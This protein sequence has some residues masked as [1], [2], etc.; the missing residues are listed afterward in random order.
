[1][2]KYLL[3][4][5]ICLAALFSSGCE[6]K[7]GILRDSSAYVSPNIQELVVE[8]DNL[9]KEV[10]GILRISCEWT[11]PAPVS[12]A[13]AYLA[14][15]QSIK[16]P[17]T[18]P[19]GILPDTEDE[20]ENGFFSIRNGKSLRAQ[21]AEAAPRPFEDSAKFYELFGT[22]MR[23]ESKIGT[24]KLFGTWSVEIPFTPRD[25]LYAPVGEHQMMIYKV[26]N[27]KKTNTLS[28]ELTIAP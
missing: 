25:L 14:F 8:A 16:D 12:R 10:G 4:T 22:P 15:V 11:S 18:E 27:G 21:E 17:H 1:M 26:I 2:F 13:H 20:N 23:L 19:I 9:S 7:T 6:G 24:E 3:L 5:I 28:F